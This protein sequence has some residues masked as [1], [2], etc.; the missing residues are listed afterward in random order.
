MGFH[1][2]RRQRGVSLVESLIVISLI[3]A[4]TT[5]VMVAMRRSQ[6]TADETMLVSQVSTLVAASRDLYR[7]TDTYAGLSNERLVDAD[8]IPDGWHNGNVIHAAAGAGTIDIATVERLGFADGAFTVTLV[9]LLDEECL[10]LGLD[11]GKMFAEVAINRAVVR[12]G[13]EDEVTVRELVGVCDGDANT[14]VGTAW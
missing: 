2:M 12:S 10:R 9:D 7:G 13:P 8:V 4:V 14:F 1:V 5:G 3:A 6:G 11:T